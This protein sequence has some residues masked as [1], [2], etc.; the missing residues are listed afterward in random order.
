MKS[1][2]NETTQNTCSKKTNEPSTARRKKA[3]G[4]FEQSGRV[5]VLQQGRRAFKRGQ[6][7]QAVRLYETALSSLSAPSAQRDDVLFELARTYEALGSLSKAK[8]IYQGLSKR[9]SML[10]RR[11]T[12]RLQAL[13]KGL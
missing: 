9:K 11:A 1:V 3:K 13:R 7:R 6:Y 10:G 8:S 4:V 2:F 12:K 5:R